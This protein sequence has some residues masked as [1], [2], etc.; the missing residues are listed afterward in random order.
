MEKN[1]L[2]GLDLSGFSDQTTKFDSSVFIETEKI[3]KM[4]IEIRKYLRKDKCFYKLSTSYGLKNILDGRIGEYVS[5]GEFIY[6]M[7][8]EG[9]KILREN[10][11]C[12]FNFSATSLRYLTNSNWIKST[13]KTSNGFDILDF[14]NYHKKFQNNKYHFKLIIRKVFSDARVLKRDIPYIIAEEI[15][16]TPENIMFWFD[17]LKESSQSIPDDKLESISK[18]F[19][20]LPNDLKNHQL[21]ELKEI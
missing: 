2:T 9:F 17:L 14:L 13:L 10:R 18:L 15:N 20:L 1:D 3:D 11:N 21:G 5:N 4:R 7:N 8:L 19:H 6:A 12:F 16:E